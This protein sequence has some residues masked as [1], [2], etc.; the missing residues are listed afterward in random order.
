MERRPGRGL[1]CDAIEASPLLPVLLQS[2]RSKEANKV[3]S[4]KSS[5][6]TSA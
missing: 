3:G 4:W 2:R 1:S 5:S 6:S